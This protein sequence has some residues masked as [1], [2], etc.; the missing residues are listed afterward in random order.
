MA[1]KVFLSV[2]S[3]F[4]EAQENFISAIEQYLT[5]NDL[6]PQTVGRTY[7]SSLQPL[8]AVNELMQECHGSIILALERTHL[9]EAVERRNSPKQVNLNNIKLT[10]PWNQIEAAMAYTH[11]HPLLVIVEDGVKHEGLMERGYDW[12]VLTVDDYTPPVDDPM[13]QAIIAD[14]K[15]RVIQFAEEKKKITVSEK[16]SD[17][18]TDS[19]K[20]KSNVVKPPAK[21][22]SSPAPSMG[23]IDIGI[24]RRNMLRAL[25]ENELADLCFDMKVDYDNLRGDSKNAKIRALILL[26]E[27]S[28]RLDELLALC[29]LVRPNLEWQHG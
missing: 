10:T 14:W 17:P 13:F 27:R 18:K 15:K 26:C 20:P 16:V 8:K 3:S 29:R 19:S 2:G 7:F 12:Y 6:K 4:S 1:Y 25:D 22:A 9:V 11:G 24:L 28:G 23:G 5:D 21:V